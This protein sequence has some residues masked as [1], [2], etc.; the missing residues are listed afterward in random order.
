[1]IVAL[2]FL[3]ACRSGGSAVVGAGSRVSLDEEWQLGNEM[4]AQVAQQVHVVHD[5]QAL[6][7][8]RN[9]GERL[10]ALTPIANRPFEF[11]IVD[12]P[13]VDVFSTP[14]GH[15]YVTSG[16]IGTAGKADE[17]AAILAHQ[18]S[19]IAARHVIK[20]AEK[21]NPGVQAFVSQVFTRD[22]EKQADDMGFDLMVR[23]GFDPH[24]MLDVYQRLLALNKARFLTQHPGSQDRIDD[25][26]GRLGKLTKTSGIVDEPDFQAIRAHFPN[27][28]H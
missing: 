15:V 12:D 24:G 21:Q 7:Y 23:A 18:I 2:L 17:L 16:L 11:E 20:Q 19:H 27:A 8:L 22:E 3:A 26:N 5:A 28:G 14:G 13:A 4:A 9:T 25:I 10:H 1:V 6:I